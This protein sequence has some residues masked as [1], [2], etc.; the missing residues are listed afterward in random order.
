MARKPRA[1]ARRKLVRKT[2]PQTDPVRAKRNPAHSRASGNPGLHTQSRQIR[3]LGPR[4]RGDERSCESGAPA[5]NKLTRQKKDSNRA[6]K[7][8]RKSPR[9]EIPTPGG[10]PYVPRHR[11][12]SPELLANGR[13]RYEETPEPVAAIAADFRIHPGS[14]RRLAHQLGWVRFAMGPRELPQ[15]ARLLAQAEALEAA[16]ASEMPENFIATLDQLEC[17]VRAEV[18]KVTA[19]REQLKNLPRRPRDAETTART[20][21]SLT[22]TLQKLQRL[23]CALPSGSHNNDDMPAD[24]DEFRNELARRIDAFVASRSQPR[25]AGRDG[26]PA[27]VGQAR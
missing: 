2:G 27:P 8:G 25:D 16:A 19:L 10:R 22:E 15:G 1:P 4:F 9:Q 26:G 3:P 23:R 24:I 13:R 7:F 20:I 21:S 6:R 17:A 14:L 12:Y 11:T 18:G 5:R